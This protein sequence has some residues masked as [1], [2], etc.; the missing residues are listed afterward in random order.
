[1]S[2]LRKDPVGDRWV[3]IASERSRRP[4][5]RVPAAMPDS[6]EPCPFCTGQERETP[7]EILAY[8]AD[9]TAPNRPGWTV[10]VVPNKYPALAV[11]EG[12]PNRHDEPGDFMAGIGAH[13]VVI[14]SPQHDVSMAN[15][16]VS[17]VGDVL[18]A[19]RERMIAL[20]EEPRWQSVVIYK[21]EGSSAGATLEHVHSQILALPMVP[22]AIADEWRALKAHDEGYRRCLYCDIIKKERERQDRVVAE[23]DAF[24]VLCPFASRFP[25]ETWIMPKRH[26][27]FFQSLGDNEL[28]QLASALLQILK[29]LAAVAD[30]PV[31]Y[32]LHSGPLRK[33]KS[34]RYHWHL[35]TLPRISKIAGFEL[36]SGYYI[37]TVTPE[38]A[39]RALRQVEI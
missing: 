4:N 15:L 5:A 13:E 1:M 35:E 31:N 29:R 6:T 24:V 34:E 25:Y 22:R 18:R 11:G 28:R 19:Y 3:I 33:A 39:A 32:V 27:P 26:S 17:Q 30:A 21:N 2:E 23:S 16:S 9:S 37:N 10:R 38:E 20:Q 12:W 14:E 36:A 8:R 7:P